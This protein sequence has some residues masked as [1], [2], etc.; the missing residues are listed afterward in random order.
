MILHFQMQRKLWLRTKL[1]FL[2]STEALQH[3]ELFIRAANII[4]SVDMS[5]K[6][7]SIEDFILKLYNFQN[8]QPKR[9]C[10]IWPYGYLISDW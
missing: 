8:F 10:E 7:C 4:L 6:C 9:A 3:W 2:T 5:Q 1:S